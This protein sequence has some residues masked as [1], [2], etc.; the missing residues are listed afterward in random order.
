MSLRIVTG[1]APSNIAL[2]K[3]MGKTDAV[4][5]LP[6][7]PS[8]SLTL[9]ALCTWAEI[10]IESSTQ[11]E[12]SWIPELPLQAS[13]GG[14]GSVPHLDPAAASR[15]VRHMER[16]QAWIEDAYPQM[17]L[18]L[19]PTANAKFTLKTANTF[20]ASSGIASSASSFAAITTVLAAANAQD[21][22][23]FEIAWNDLTFR[24]KLAQLSR[25]GSGSSCRS[26]EGPWVLWEKDQAAVVEAPHTPKLA[27]FVIL[28]SK[29]KKK[30]S[31]SAAHSLIRTSPLWEGRVA[32]VEKRKILSLAAIAQGD[33]T[34]LAK[35]A[36]N[37]AWEMHSLFHTCSEPF[38]YW[39]PGTIDALHWFALKMQEA[40]PPIVTLD[41]GPNV[42]VMVEKAHQTAWREKLRAH[43]QSYEILE[44]EQGSG[45]SIIISE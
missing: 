18:E 38:S 42:H 2:I 15:V 37:E 45:A 32:R 9:N 3:Y 41:A 31:S 36:W 16:V 10:A 27:H 4:L 13:K 24:R 40:S 8:L 44:D 11:R 21:Y 25:Q 28:I 20:P 7:N 29:E 1:K 34:A 23:T 12:M 26:F 14:R 6:E 17:G 22:A 33:L 19:H 43:F 30:T 39:Q 35:I 5:N